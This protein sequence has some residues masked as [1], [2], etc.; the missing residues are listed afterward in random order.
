MTGLFHLHNVFK[1]HPCCGMCR[2]LPPF[3][4]RIILP[5]IYKPHFVVPSSYNVIPSSVILHCIYWPHHV[6]SWWR[7]V[8]L[9]HLYLIV[10]LKRKR[11][12]LKGTKKAPS[13]H[14]PHSA[15]C[16]ATRLAQPP[17]TPVVINTLRWCFWE[18]KLTVRATYTFQ[19]ITRKCGFNILVFGSD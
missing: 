11:M 12:L 9:L 1:V 2:N 10:H 18:Q 13:T 7:Q 17:A 19:S 16:P 4:T 6:I 14:D 15:G 3:Y 8:F 5:C